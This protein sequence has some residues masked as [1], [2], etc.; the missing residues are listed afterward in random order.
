M[1]KSILMV[2][3]IAGILLGTP[4]ADAL[5]ERWD[6]P[7][8]PAHEIVIDTRPDFIYLPKPGFYV[9][10]N[11]PFDIIFYGNRYYVLRDGSWYAASHHRGPWVVV[12]NNAL[13]SR[14]KRYQWED[15]RRY[16]E[17]EYNRHDR[18]Y[19]D[20]QFEHDRMRYDGRDHDGRRGRNDDRGHGPTD[21][22]GHGPEG[23]HGNPGPGGPR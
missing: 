11:G 3:G 8:R 1:K 13:P 17:R 9:S 21:G 16:R 10:F 19:W 7:G 12:R 4:L 22:P 6:G 2:T 14:I 18:R 15:L 20:N 23:P 5:A